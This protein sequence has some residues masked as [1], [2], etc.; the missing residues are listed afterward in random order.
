MA[1]LPDRNQLPTS[2]RAG[3]REKVWGYKSQ[4]QAGWGDGKNN[5]KERERGE[6]GRE[7]AVEREKRKE[8]K[9]KEREIQRD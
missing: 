1:G 8:K 6:K 2:S 9:K 4:K 3:R 5:R 7:T